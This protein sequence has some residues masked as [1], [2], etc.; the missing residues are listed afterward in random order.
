MDTKAE[1]NPE[2]ELGNLSRN[3]DSMTG[4]VEP[5]QNQHEFEFG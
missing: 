5:Q 1:F 4:F 2:L 3:Q